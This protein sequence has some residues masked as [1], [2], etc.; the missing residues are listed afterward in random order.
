MPLPPG[1]RDLGRFPR[2]GTNLGP[3]PPVPEN[4]ALEVAGAVT[5]PFAVPLGELEQRPRRE[6]VA[7]LHCVAGWSATG[8]R[9]EGVPFADFYRERIEPV[10]A[11]GARVTHV[12][13]VSLEGYRVYA[14]LEDALRDD[15]L[16]AFKLDGEP[17]DGDHGAPL[18]FVSPSQYGYVNAKHLCR[19]ELHEAEPREDYGRAG[20][21]MLKLVGFKRHPRARVWEEERH[22]FLPAWTVRRAYR[23]FIAPTKRLSKRRHA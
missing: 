13:L 3:P 17:L 8:L 20:N 7:D 9:W 18:R 14:L 4:P 15:V 5:E 23:L 22:R 19:I 12:L 6:V 10:L 16:L 21:L 1:Q 11:P 2:F